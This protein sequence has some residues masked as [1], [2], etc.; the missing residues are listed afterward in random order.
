MGDS[1]VK[2]HLT[3]GVSKKRCGFIVDG[4]AAREH[5]DIF[6]KDGKKVGVV[7]SGSHSPCLKKSIG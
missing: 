7:T 3:E 5:T 6:N 2:K 4:I 1:I